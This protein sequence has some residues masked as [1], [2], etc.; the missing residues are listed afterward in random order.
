VDKKYLQIPPIN[1]R[2]TIISNPFATSS[3]NGL[4]S[5]RLSEAKLAGRIFAYNP[6]SLRILRRPCS[7][8][9]GPT[10]HLG[11]PTA[12]SHI[13]Y[14]SFSSLFPLPPF[15]PCVSTLVD[16]SCTR[17]ETDVPSKIASA[18]LHDLSVSS[19]NGS[20]EASI[21]APP[22]GLDTISSLSE[23]CLTIVSRTRTAS[24]VTSGPGHQCIFLSSLSASVLGKR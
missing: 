3:F 13:S 17:V 20:P 2:T 14:H 18:S 12:P 5:N 8:L 24:A 7:G 4:Y 1:S 22:K 16:T 6:N 23:V 19:G 10:P 11:P 9:T 15:Y 21:P